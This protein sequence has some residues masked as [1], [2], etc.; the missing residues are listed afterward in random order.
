M[1]RPKKFGLWTAAAL[2]VGCAAA[3]GCYFCARWYGFEV[4]AWRGASAWVAV[5]PKDSRLSESM[6]VAL[7]DVVPQAQSGAFQ[8]ERRA[9]GLETA[10]LPVLAEGKEVD[11]LLLVRIDPAKYRFEVRNA[12]AG[13]RDL[14][15][16]MN[17]LHAVVVTNGSY[18]TQDGTPATPLLSD[19]TQLGPAAYHATHGAFAV[20][21]HF[22]GLYDLQQQDWRDLFRQA[23]PKF[24]VA[25]GIR[26]WFDSVIFRSGVSLTG[27]E[28]D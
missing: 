2:L 6:R 5:T 26:V 24:A 21:D 20:S 7:R 28:R 25:G 9:E 16:W 11:R 3:A 27:H 12:P 14:S 23:R 10:E 4:I 15:N 13:D 19:R 17:Q 18:F 8:W 22:T 1:S